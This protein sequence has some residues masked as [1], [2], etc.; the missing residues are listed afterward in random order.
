[1]KTIGVI[2][3]LALAVVVFGQLNMRSLRFA[4]IVEARNY[5]RVANEDLAKS[6]SVTNYNGS[7]KVWVS[8]N[9]VNVN[10]TDHG[11]KLMVQVHKFYDEGTL[12]QTTNDLLIWLG[13]GKPPKL[14]T[15]D[16]RPRLF[17]PRF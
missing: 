17:P 12:A 2:L 3:L 13:S 4:G 7:Y 14:I 9:V 11:C 16:Y 15:A 5:L 6:G 8:T 1:V 10:G